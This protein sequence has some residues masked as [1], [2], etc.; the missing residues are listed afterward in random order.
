M[1][2]PSETPPD[3]LKT[4]APV[5]SSTH[6]QP[7][8]AGGHNVEENKGSLRTESTNG[9][10]PIGM[11]Q[12]IGRYR[13]VRLLGEGA[14][15][16]VY[17][18]HDEEADR[19]VAIKV[20]RRDRVCTADDGDA[21]LAEARVVAQLDHPA[22]VP[23]YDIVR[24]EDGQVCVVSKYVK[25]RDLA[26]LMNEKRV[27]CRQAALLAADVADALHYAHVRGLVHRDIKPGN[28]LL[29]EHDRPYVADFGLALREDSFGKGAR[30]AGTPAYMSPEQARAEGHRVDG[31]SDIF[32]LGVV[33]YEML[34]GKRPFAGE[35]LK[36]ILDQITTIEPRPLRQRDDSI[37]KELERICLK[38]LAK[39][40][41]DRYTTAKDLAEDLRGYAA[42]ESLVIG[43]VTSRIGE[44]ATARSLGAAPTPDLAPSVG[45]KIMPKGLRA[46]DAADADFFLELLPGPR[47]RDG[48]PESLRFWKLRIETT[49]ADGVFPVGLLYGPSGCGKSSLLKAGLLPRLASHVIPI[50]VEATSE[51]TE[52]RLLRALRK[53][54]PEAS[55]EQDL[56]DTLAALR[57][58]E[59]LR[60]GQKVLIVLDQ[61]EQWL[62]AHCE[63]QNS[64]LTLALR[65]CDGTHVQAIVLVRDDFWM[66]ATRFFRELEIRL[67]EG[68]N[69][70]AVDLFDLQH[71]R[72]VLAAFGRA[73]RRLPEYP[74]QLTPKQEAFLDQAVRELAEDGKVISVRLALLAEMFKSRE[75]TPRTLRDVGG[76]AGVGVAFL[77]ETFSAKTAPP[78]HRVHQLAVRGVLEKLLPEKGTEIKGHVRSRGELLAASGYERTPH[79]FSRLLE[80]LTKELR[81]ITPT[82]PAGASES[83]ISHDAAPTHEFYQLTHDYLVVS[84]RTWLTRKQR[85]TRQ[86]RAELRLAELASFWNAK[87]EARRLPSFM[88]YLSIRAHTR[89]KNWPVAHQAMMTAAGRRYATRAGVFILLLGIA[90]FAVTES[91]SRVRSAA[92][93]ES[94]LSA[95]IAE[96]PER[97]SRDAS[98]A[99]WM[100]PRLRSVAETEDT[101]TVDD[102][103][104]L[105]AMLA[106]V[107]EEPRYAEPLTAALLE[108]TSTE[109]TVIAQ[110]LKPYVAQVRDRLWIAAKTDSSPARRFNAASGLAQLDPN[111]AMWSE[112][113]DDVAR[114]LV[115]TL[116]YNPRD[117]D[118]VVEL[119]E[120]VG[121]NLAEPLRERVYAADAPAAEREAA[122]NVFLEYG[123]DQ[124]SSFAR[125]L[126]DADREQFER[127]LEIAR[128]RE[129][130]IASTLEAELALTFDAVP[131]EA[132]KEQLAARQANAAIAL[133]R[134]GQG[135][136][137]W[138]RLGDGADP[139]LSAYFIERAG[140]FG[141]DPAILTARLPGMI[142]PTAD[143][144]ASAVILLAL[145]G[146]SQQ[147]IPPALRESLGRQVV[148]L[149]RG[150]PDAA[151]HGAAASLLRAWGQ[152][153]LRSAKS[154]MPGESEPRPST[155]APA[156]RRGWFVNAQG[157]TFVILPPAEFLMG[158]PESEPHREPEEV[159]HRRRIPRT[160]A[161][162]ATETTRGQ[163][164]QF[165]RERY[166]E[167]RAM[168]YEADVAFYSATDDAPAVRVNWF[169]AAEYCNWLSQKEGIPEDQECYT[170]NAEGKYAAGMQVKANAL[171]LTG[172]RLPL[173]DE[174]EYACRAGTATMRP[175]GSSETIANAYAWSQQ[176]SENRAW[177]IA[178]LKPNP[179]GVFDM[180]GN[181]SEWCH[182]RYLQDAYSTRRT[183]PPT[184]EPE[185]VENEGRSLRGGAFYFPAKT[186]RSADRDFNHADDRALAVG[187]RTARTLAPSP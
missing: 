98:Y 46:F 148:A 83:A 137:V 125:A 82:D 159:L 96:A 9:N 61:F 121:G 164:K 172:Y 118:T 113:R 76:A 184:T 2:D 79:D 101:S 5:P 44:P 167:A 179:F 144:A 152:E 99:R 57:R 31:R 78:E 25:G 174:W 166:D 33:L 35:S 102:K 95:D 111:G 73:Y 12:R 1:M 107:G 106:L 187:F 81:L 62:H 20:P 70:A 130:R 69:S 58:G 55:G 64:P 49:D 142:S 39:R 3:P 50:Y 158:S 168:A 13:V 105:R 171:A 27:P 90:V 112:V 19:E 15:G 88:E 14:F 59:S 32:S 21:Y 93:V 92:L 115:R 7:D 75:W 173:E 139:R 77:E 36:E 145:E 71:A 4:E 114:Q 180:L 176:N 53:R 141:L 6:N 119:L 104:R 116:A 177:P 94:L 63:E 54:F 16:S 132:S 89:S 68:E 170:P 178:S 42:E 110:Q 72:C 45:A 140:Q 154:G 91:Y 18:S 182:D 136:Q 160:L 185:T 151:L 30:F 128:A 153:V 97:L 163:F 85:E 143:V 126:L 51:D 120:P 80:I 29:D 146:Y 127:M 147:Q 86:G 165:L 23:V 26:S 133:L 24:T 38:A 48:W 100:K 74:A 161:L 150:H 156:D 181:V 169:E 22:I 124:P 183:E 66:A 56:L 34:T 117:F 60:A 149:Y 43:H 123:V 17:L 8:T 155:L 67:V 108:A 103:A 87:R 186:I 84:I 175:C 157:Q 109:V 37:P 131:D 135:A 122:L 28:I 162:A 40:A 41:A 52:A 10:V 47:D 11:P 134:I 129:I 138:N 65:Q